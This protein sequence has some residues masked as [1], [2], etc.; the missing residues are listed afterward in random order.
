MNFMIA[1][2]TDIGVVRNTNQDSI[3]C[4]VGQ[5]NNSAYAFGVVC[6]GMGGLAKGELASA[7]LINAMVSWFKTDFP[8]LLAK[9][10]E[11]ND[12]R[13]QWTEIVR[14]NN[15]RIMEY[16]A[17]NGF[18]LGTTVSAILL[19]EQRYYIINVGDSGIYEITDCTKQ[20]TEDQTVVARE[21]KYG[22]LT[23][24]QAKRDPRKS[25]LLQCVGATKNVD[26]DFFFG[27][28]VAGAVYLL[29][30]DGFRHEISDDEMYRFFSASI[31]TTPDL[32][33]GHIREL[34]E[35]NKQRGEKDNISAALIR[36][37]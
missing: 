27:T 29:C 32:M 33:A 8:K 9:G 11:D 12:I 36:T 19:T 7:T 18:N 24:E 23:P 28:P 1:A 34:I 5:T 22:R 10:L 3:A 35:I 13:T 4:L 6:D 15:A 17:A 21:V 2:D 25:V 20:L 14:S 16:G 30:S 31:N 37:V 26:P